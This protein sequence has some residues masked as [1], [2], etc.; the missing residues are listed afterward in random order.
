M[1]QVLCSLLLICFGTGPCEAV[2]RS[3]QQSFP[4]DVST[5]TPQGLKVR[6]TCATGMTMQM[7]RREMV[8]AAAAAILAA[9]LAASASG[10]SPK[11]VWDPSLEC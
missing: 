7:D 9:P 8:K 1:M 2:P 4:L 10:D 5:C 11:Q 3:R 6:E